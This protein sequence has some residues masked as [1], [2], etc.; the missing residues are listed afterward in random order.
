MSSDICVEVTLRSENKRFPEGMVVPAIE[1]WA[2]CRPAPLRTADPKVRVF[3][4]EL[5]DPS[6]DFMY[7]LENVLMGTGT[8]I[9]RTL[10]APA[11]PG[12]HADT[13][14]S[15]GLQIHPLQDTERFDCRVD[16]CAKHAAAR[17][18]FTDHPERYHAGEYCPRHTLETLEHLLVET[19]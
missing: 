15:A 16:G 6:Q 1:A 9:V 5:C 19:A 13:G 8:R 11:G 3:T 4:F 12:P 2:L 10:V 14:S 7:E 17:I 18:T